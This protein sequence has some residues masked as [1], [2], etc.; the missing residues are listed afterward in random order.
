MTDAT[1]VTKVYTEVVAPYSAI[2]KQSRMT[3]MYVEVIGAIPLTTHKVP[4]IMACA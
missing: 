1:R 4:I 2:V 3:R